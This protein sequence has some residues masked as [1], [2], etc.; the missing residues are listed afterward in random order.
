MRV[1]SR[2]VDVGGIERLEARAAFSGARPDANPAYLIAPA[3]ARHDGRCAP[4][5]HRCSHRQ[6]ARWH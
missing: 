5:A 3:G 2:L 6:A 1:N 4:R